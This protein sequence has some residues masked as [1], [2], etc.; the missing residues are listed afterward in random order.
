MATVEHKQDVESSAV[1]SIW[2]NG[3]TLQG[4]SWDTYVKFVEGLGERRV[5]VTYD[6]GLMEIQT[7][8]P[9]LP[10]EYSDRFLERFIHLMAFLESIEISCGGSTTH[11]RE[12]LEK[13]M[14]LDSCFWIA[15]AANMIGVKELDVTKVPPP[16]LVIEIDI[17]ASSVDRIEGFCKLGVPEIWHIQDGELRFLVLTGDHYA[18][19]PTSRSFPSVDRDSVAK[20]MQ[21]IEELGETEALNQL[22]TKLKLR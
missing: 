12:D 10:H 15:N 1:P 19:N 6:R 20:A 22:L 11:R 7:M 18:E 13:G 8:S 3:I 9:S 5:F 16:D 14:E 2:E 17:H 4:V 21:A